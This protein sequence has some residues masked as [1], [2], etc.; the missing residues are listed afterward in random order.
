MYSIQHFDEPFTDASAPTWPA[1]RQRLPTPLPLGLPAAFRARLV[2]L[3][4]E[5]ALGDAAFQR[6]YFDLVLCP[7]LRARL[8]EADEAGVRSLFTSPGFCWRQHL[9]ERLAHRWR[10]GLLRQGDGA[11]IDESLG[12]LAGFRELAE[13]LPEAARH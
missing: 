10:E 3:A 6:L 7:Q 5:T 2:Q 8:N 1:K 13:T 4:H 9:D 12:L 11:Y